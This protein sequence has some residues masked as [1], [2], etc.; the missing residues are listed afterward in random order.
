MVVEEPKVIEYFSAE[1]EYAASIKERSQQEKDTEKN[2]ILNHVG[3][4]HYAVR[5]K[6]V[7]DRKPTALHLAAGL[8]NECQGV[9]TLIDKQTTRY[10][11][12]SLDTLISLGAKGESSSMVLSKDQIRT[13][14]ETTPLHLAVKKQSPIIILALLKL[15]DYQPARYYAALFLMAGTKGLPNNISALAQ[16]NIEGNTLLH[17]PS[18]IE[19]PNS[20]TIIHWVVLKIKSLTDPKSEGAVVYEDDQVETLHIMLGSS[21]VPESQNS[22]SI[23]E[24][25]DKGIDGF[26]YKYTYTVESVPLKNENDINEVLGF[27]NDITE[28]FYTHNKNIHKLIT[29]CYIVNYHFEAVKREF[30]KWTSCI[31]SFQMNNR[32]MSRIRSFQMNNCAQ[33]QRVNERTNDNQVIIE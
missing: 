8:R 5:K 1:V 11:R 14:E 7:S 16:R 24:Y 29:G 19:L 15:L 31:R 18:E 28:F 33:N 25:I 26:I 17:L 2:I 6:L 21:F 12:R 10:T 23:L 20:K 9:P 13:V 32:V 22:I 27:D 30:D 3:A 4:H